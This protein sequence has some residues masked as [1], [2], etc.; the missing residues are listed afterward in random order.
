[1]P[2]ETKKRVYLTA[3]DLFSQ[4]GFGGTS[5]KEIA[6]TIGVRQA[7]IYNHFK[8]K[9][10]ILTAIFAD[11]EDSYTRHRPKIDT[12]W[13]AYAFFSF[14]Y[15]IPQKLLL[16][17]LVIAEVE[18]DFAAGIQYISATYAALL[19]PSSPV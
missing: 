10:D 8:A 15:V 19:D 7:S 14:S 4:K 12:R 11:F 3:I 17:D 2:N 16:H 13:L 9:E 5:L 1:M 18:D 6:E